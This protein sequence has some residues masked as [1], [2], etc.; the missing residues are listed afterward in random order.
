MQ[1]KVLLF[2][3]LRD[4]V[5]ASE[6]VVRLS[7][8]ARAADLVAH[9]R[10]RFPSLEEICPRLALAIN[11]EYAG[12]TTLL[13][14]GDE[15][16]LLPPVSGGEEEFRV[17]A[18]LTRERLDPDALAARLSTP[19]DG[20][21]VTFAGT[22]RRW[23]GERET[24]WLEYEAYQPMALN[25]FREIAAE[26]RDRFRAGGVALAHRLGRLEIGETCVVVAVSAPHRAAAFDACRY[27]IDTLKRTAPIW[28]KERLADGEVWA[29]GELPGP[30]VEPGRAKAGA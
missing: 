8:G 2:G 10:Q 4:A 18:Q 17:I 13:H 23:T 14:G 5:G 19:R 30:A 15:V 16:A 24:L 6:E 12:R 21:L 7:E 22:A 9:Y 1:V 25:R 28:K 29:E 20:A 3:Q 26:V 27:A 11:Q